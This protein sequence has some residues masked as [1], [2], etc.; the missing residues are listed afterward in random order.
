MR[1]LFLLALV[2]FPCHSL[3]QANDT[4]LVTVG[5]WILARAEAD[6]FS[7]AVL[8]ARNGVPLLRR[9]YGFAN[10][11]TKEPVT[12]ETR[13][14]LGSIDKLITRI[15]IWQLVAAGKLQL[16]V[17]V[18]RYLPDYP[19]DAVRERVTA[20][21]LYEMRSGVGNFMNE[22]YLARHAEIRTVDQYL[23]LFATEPLQFEPG[24]GML[25][26]N[27]GYIILGKLIERLTEMSYYDYVT[28]HITEPAGMGATQHYLIDAAVP[29]RAV[30]YTASQ[31]PLRPN[32]YSLAGR[33]SPAGGGY[34]TVDDF[35]KLD[36]ALREGR[37]LPAAFDS[38]L[39]PSFKRGELVSYGGGG[40]GTNTQY[41]AWND[42]LTIL[43]FSNRDPSAGTLVA[44]EIAKALGRTI[45]GGQRV[46]RRPG[47]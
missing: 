46:I 27:G 2:A 7:G 8:V 36:A 20:R 42:G 19:N 10:R 14:N 47:G 4:A 35:L 41:A 17:P 5:G 37:L 38:I 12:P 22:E 43:V 16:D 15:A 6:S 40:P 3:A 44:Q 32:T 1:P 33:G 30:G 21:H 18:G 45:P 11:E 23:S 24:T 34:S 13:F 28:K 9:G 39:G 26:S 31:G 25:Y 29:N